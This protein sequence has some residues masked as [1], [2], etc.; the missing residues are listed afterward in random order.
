MSRT[1]Q[2]TTPSTR[3]SSRSLFIPRVFSNISK[4]RI[5]K[6]F[7]SLDLGVVDTIDFVKK[8]GANGTYHSVY[9]HL[10]YWLSTAASRE[11]RKK[12]FCEE[13]AQQEGDKQEGVKQEGVKQEGAKLIYDDPWFWVVLPNTSASSRAPSNPSSRATSRRARSPNKRDRHETPTVKAL[14]DAKSPIAPPYLERGAKE[15]GAKERDAKVRDAKVRDAKVIDAKI[16]PEVKI[17]I[18]RTPSPHTPPHSP[19]KTPDHAP[20]PMEPKMMRDPPALQRKSSNMSNMDLS[21]MELSNMELSNM[22]ANLFAAEDL[23]A[24][25][26]PRPRRYSEC[27]D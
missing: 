18:P 7:D 3:P 6:V 8:Q 12:L 13:G 4:E 26:P 25:F 27:S 15:R 11:F 9:V 23:L 14:R 20:P 19:P 24:R 17:E 1:T 21:N 2:N 5:A 16:H 10:K 22:E